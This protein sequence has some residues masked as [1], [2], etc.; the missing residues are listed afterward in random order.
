MLFAQFRFRTPTDGRGSTQDEFLLPQKL[1]LKSVHGCTLLRESL[2]AGL[3]FRGN[4]Q[5]VCS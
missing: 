5:K 4:T 1:V 2:K 3:N